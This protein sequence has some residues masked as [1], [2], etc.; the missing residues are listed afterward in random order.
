M[1]K[2]GITSVA[3]LV[4]LA[5]NEGIGST[6]EHETRACSRFRYGGDNQQ[7]LHSASLAVSH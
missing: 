4:C 5:Q 6:A 7:F 1:Q 3:A 2:L